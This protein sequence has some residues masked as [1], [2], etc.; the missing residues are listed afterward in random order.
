MKYK[1]EKSLTTVVVFT[2][3]EGKKEKQIIHSKVSLHRNAK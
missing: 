1:L 3:R 2:G